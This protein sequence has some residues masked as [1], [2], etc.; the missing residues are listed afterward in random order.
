[1]SLL[2]KVLE[3]ETQQSIAKQ[4]QM[5]HQRALPDL[6]SNIKC[7][8]SLIGLDFYGD[9]LMRRLDDE[10][11]ARVNV[12]D[13]KSA[14]PRVFSGMGPGFDIVLGNPPYGYMISQV[15]RD[16]FAKHYKHQD[17]QTDLYLL[18]LE[19]YEQLL[20]DT[21]RLGVIVSNT[22]LQSITLRKIRQHLATTYRWQRV[23]LLPAKVFRATVDTHVLVFDKGGIA[24]GQTRSLSV[25]I[26]ERTRVRLLHTLP[27]SAIDRSGDPINVASSLGL[28]RLL[29]RIRTESRPLSEVCAVYNGI[30]PFEKGKGTPPQTSEI[31]R[32]R[33]F[34]AVG[35]KP[36]GSWSP[37]LRGSLIRRYELVWK[38][39]YWIQYGPW[40]AAPRE[41][42]I[43]DA[44]E[45]IMIRQTGDSLIATLIP[46]GFFA[47]NNMHIILPKDAAYDL[48]Y[49]LGIIN[50]T[51]MSVLYSL[52]NPER[53]ETFAEVKKAHVEQLPICPRQFTEPA[54]RKQRDRLIALVD[55]QLKLREKR[56]SARTAD[57]RTGIERQLEAT[58]RQTDRVVF[59]LYGLTTKE[60]ALVNDEADRVAQSTSATPDG[61]EEDVA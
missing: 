10:L 15:E 21:G 22:W 16:Y 46:S 20:K 40:L 57:E 30:K 39:D 24:K 6:S 2:L 48:R 43:F 41:R 27:S 38:N 29:R 35:P 36:G 55:D 59:D 31:A 50:S 45:K 54:C 60:M 47:R 58:E 25:D 49:L 61:A 17:Y 14:F 12:F 32:N 5:F 56:L 8:N 19:R 3:G 34:V 33:P 9:D 28:Q 26:C 11:K 51:L 23:L 18:F 4:L 37:L 13:W 44:P 52:M 1:M 7:G 53:G 42:S